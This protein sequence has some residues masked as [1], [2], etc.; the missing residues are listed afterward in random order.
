MRFMERRHIV[1][2]IFDRLSDKSKVHTST[3]VVKT[4]SH[5]GR[6]TV[7]TNDGSVFEGD[8]VVGADGIHSRVRQEMQRLAGEETDGRE[9]FPDEDGEFANQG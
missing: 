6:V 1:Q 2:G 4:V 9:L 3:E 8:V 7:E 5:P